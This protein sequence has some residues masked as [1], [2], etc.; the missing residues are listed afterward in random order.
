MVLVHGAG[1]G[2]REKLREEAAA[3]AR[4]GV[5][6]LTYDKRTVGYSLTQRSY[7]QLA[8]DAAAAAA[9]LRGRPEVA[10]SAVGIWGFS[11]GGWVAPLA[12]SRAPETAF[13]VVVGAN[14]VAPLRQQTWATR[15]RCTT[16]ASRA[17]SWTRA[18]ARSTG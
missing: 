1:T 17:R 16:P 10:P 15:P 12:A 5:A 9:V 4:A 14:G 11:E 8:D 6:T 18:P 7:A 13:V 3:F 2:P